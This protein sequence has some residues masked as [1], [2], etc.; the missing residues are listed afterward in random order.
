VIK[1]NKV[2]PSIK[3]L[4]KLIGKFVFTFEASLGAVNPCAISLNN[5]YWKSVESLKKIHLINLK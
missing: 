1:I 4:I 2:E 3:E 5:L